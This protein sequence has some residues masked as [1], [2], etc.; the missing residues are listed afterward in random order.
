MKL[1]D[2]I[3]G[4]YHWIDR[5]NRIPFW[6]R[7]FWPYVHWCWE[8]D[9]LLIT[10]NYCDCFC[11]VVPKELAEAARGEYRSVE[12]DDTLDRHSELLRRLK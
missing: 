5:R 6:A 8:M 10:D 1:T 11:G 9:G 12:L 7:W 2:D 4:I 3:F